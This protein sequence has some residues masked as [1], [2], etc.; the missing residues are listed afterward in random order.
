MNSS[1]PHISSETISINPSTVKWKE[2]ISLGALNAAI[3]ISW[4]AYLEYQ[5][6]LLDKFHLG[7]LYGWL[8]VAKALILICIPVLA[9]WIADRNLILNGRFFT[10]YLVGI[11]ATAMIFMIVATITGFGPESPVAFLLP[12]M[13]ICWLIGMALFL[14]PAFSM[15]TWFA[16]KRRLPIAMGVIILLTDLIYALEPLV[17]S[18]VR[19]LGETMTFVTGG[20]L[21][22]GTG[23]LFYRLS[24]K[25]VFYRIQRTAHARST[26]TEWG[27]V[28][29]VALLVGLGRAFLVEYVP[30]QSP[31]GFMSGQEFSFLLLGLAAITAFLSSRIV[32][33]TGIRKVINYAAL[34]MGI[35]IS[36]ML[37][38]SANE[39]MFTGGCLILAF[40]FALVNVAGLP[41]VFSRISAR[42]TT[43]AVGVFL[44]GTAL[45]E[46]MME[47]LSFLL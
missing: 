3:A 7:H 1:A 18:L 42:H 12:A 11:N 29:S 13:V 45:A 24:A 23:Y 28:V 41:Y 35:G 21:I 32:I 34:I 6:A 46:G 19:F 2:I 20:I 10:I 9:G 5:P 17:I 14:A 26:R 44:G 47:I 36:V 22:L 39:V 43:F 27:I 15:L 40:G 25:D 8:V 31:V 37:V 38:G 4:I 16:D 33:R 30:W